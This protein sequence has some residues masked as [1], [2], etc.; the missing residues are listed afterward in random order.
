MTTE[1]DKPKL[2]IAICLPLQA[3]V[4]EPV[5]FFSLKMFEANF[6]QQTSANVHFQ[7][8]F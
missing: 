8:L 7:V 5:L 4:S 3:I 2:S 1:P 6:S